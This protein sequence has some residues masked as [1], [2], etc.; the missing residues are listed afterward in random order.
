[1][2]ALWENFITA[3]NCVSIEVH[4]VLQLLLDRIL[5]AI[6]RNLAKSLAAIPVAESPL[7][8]VQIA[9]KEGEV[10]LC[11]HARVQVCK[12]W[13]KMRSLQIDIRTCDSLLTLLQSWYACN[14]LFPLIQ[15]A[16]RKPLH[17]GEKVISYIAYT[18]VLDQTYFESCI[19]AAAVQ[20]SARLELGL[21]RQ[22]ALDI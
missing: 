13:A 10:L 14:L 7:T 2:H 19:T 18:F 8:K 20:L 21:C 6:L 5:K 1:M 3:T 22:C 4:L 15:I 12:L 16:T 17:K 9:G 11:M